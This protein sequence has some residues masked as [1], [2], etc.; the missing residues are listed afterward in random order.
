[1]SDCSAAAETNTAWSKEEE[2]EDE[3]EDEGSVTGQL[4]GKNMFYDA[5]ALHGQMR[6][7]ANSHLIYSMLQRVSW[8]T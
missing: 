4:R 8:N 1:M 7:S 6:L 2:E 3:E 5:A